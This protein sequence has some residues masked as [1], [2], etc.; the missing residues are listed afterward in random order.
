MEELMQ[1]DERLDTLND[2]HATLERAIEK[3]NLRPH[4]D[5]IRISEL[6]RE[7]LRIKDEIHHHVE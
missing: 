2:K 5:D 7:K 6:K 1:T 4:P 3:E